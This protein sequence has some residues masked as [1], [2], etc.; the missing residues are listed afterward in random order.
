ME[1]QVLVWTCIAVF[2][3]TATI[4]LLSIIGKLK[5]PDGYRDK[6]FYLLII[7]IV[8][9]GVLAFKNFITEKQKTCPSIVR[10]VSPSEDF[11]AT[12]KQGNYFYIEGY[13]NKT[14]KESLKG[15][16][17][18]NNKTVNLAIPQINN[19]GIFS[20][21]FLIADSLI[22][23]KVIC[24]IQVMDSSKLISEDE[25]SFLITTTQ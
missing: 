21:R 7:E 19:K 8:S 10:I 23:Q 6:L 4:T 13:C 22:N 15:T 2:I 24:K 16:A 20:T 9:F 14:D 18:I 17:T 5:I 25:R 12:L 1:I 11:S 3:A